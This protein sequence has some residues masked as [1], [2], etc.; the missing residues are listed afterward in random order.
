MEALESDGDF[1]KKLNEASEDDIRSG[2]I[3]HQLEFV[4]HQ[5]RSKLDEIKREEIERLRSLVKQQVSNP[6]WIG[7]IFF[8]SIIFQYQLNNQIDEHHLKVNQLAHVDHENLDTFEIEDL[9]KLIKKTSD[10]LSAAD[11]ARREEFKVRN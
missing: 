10:D 3:A 7:S 4:N 1:R 11:K 6:K 9:K 2:N 5:V 8:I